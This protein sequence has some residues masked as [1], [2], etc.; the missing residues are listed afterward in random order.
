MKDFIVQA[1][2]D[3]ESVQMMRDVADLM[4]AHHSPD[5]SILYFGHLYTQCNAQG[6]N[7][8]G[9]VYMVCG[10]QGEWYIYIFQ[11]HKSTNKR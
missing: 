10:K 7:N 5:Q 3:Y 6:G 11:Q 4:K 9:G 1:F 2:Q 8:L